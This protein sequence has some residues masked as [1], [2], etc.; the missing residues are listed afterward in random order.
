MIIEAEKYWETKVS[1]NVQLHLG[2]TEVPLKY[3]IAFSKQL[4]A[5][6]CTSVNTF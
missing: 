2:E 3:A 6:L 1:L 4:G 5:Y